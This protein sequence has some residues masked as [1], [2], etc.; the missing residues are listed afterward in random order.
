MDNQKLEE[1]GKSIFYEYV[2]AYD[3]DN[4]VIRFCT[5]WATQ[6]EDVDTLLSLI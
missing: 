4:T 6:E 5:S 1:L 3:D 2:E